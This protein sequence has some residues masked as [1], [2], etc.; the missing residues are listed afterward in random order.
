MHHVMAW[1]DGKWT[2]LLSTESLDEA[3]ERYDTDPEA[4]GIVDDKRAADLIKR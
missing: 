3:K 1:K 4:E 2:V